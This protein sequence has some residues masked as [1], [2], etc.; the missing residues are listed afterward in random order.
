M[1]KQP[2]YTNSNNFVIKTRILSFPSFGSLCSGQLFVRRTRRRGPS[3]PRLRNRRSPAARSSVSAGPGAAPAGR[4]RPPTPD[5]RPRAARRPASSEGALAVRGRGHS[6]FTRSDC[7]L[8]G[9]ETHGHSGLTVSGA[10]AAWFSFGCLPPRPGHSRSSPF[11]LG[12]PRAT[13][14]SSPGPPG[15]S[16]PAPHFLAVSLLRRT[17]PGLSCNRGSREANFSREGA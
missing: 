5:P 11:L 3:S 8:S 10:S 6:A 16:A 7:E 1:K 15:A 4:P 14:T 2:S 9:R 12:D 13:R 17:S